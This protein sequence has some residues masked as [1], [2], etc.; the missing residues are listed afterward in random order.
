[1]YGTNIKSIMQ[2]IALLSLMIFAVTEKGKK[3]RCRGNE[4]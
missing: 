4:T 3:A 2:I 1:M